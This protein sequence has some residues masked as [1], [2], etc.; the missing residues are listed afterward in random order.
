MEM[1]RAK[2]ERLKRGWTQAE[3][4]ARVGATSTRIGD[5]ESGRVKG[6]RYGRVL[7][8][9]AR[10][11]EIKPYQLFDQVQVPVELGKDVQNWRRNGYWVES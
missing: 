9:L 10:L 11:Y 5:I 4:A 1:L 6:T 3:V 7:M 2:Y 8:N